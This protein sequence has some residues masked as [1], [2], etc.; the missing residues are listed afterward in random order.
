MTRAA[1]TLVR[2]DVSGALSYH[3]LVPLIAA[4][5]VVGWIWFVLVRLGVVRPA[6]NRT[7]TIILAVTALALVSVWV[8]RLISGTLPPV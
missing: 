4:Q 2:G 8:V 6:G 7:V 1:S 5:L 3:P